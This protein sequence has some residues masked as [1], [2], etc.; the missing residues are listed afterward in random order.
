MGSYNERERMILKNTQSVCFDQMEQIT[1]NH[2]I[3]NQELNALYQLVDVLKDIKTM[4]AMDEVD[5]NSYSYDGYSQG[6][7]M[8]RMNYSY[9]EDGYSQMRTPHMGWGYPNDG[10]SYQNR[11]MRTGRYSRDEGKTQFMGE[12]QQMLN[13][14]TTEKERNAIM[15]CMNNLEG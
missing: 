11:N 15:Q 4:C 10:M 12:L 3:N 8:P 7:R 13:N 2:D 9:D 1:A 5:A 14:A 6:M